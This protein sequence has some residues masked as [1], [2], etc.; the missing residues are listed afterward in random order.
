[1][2]S[3][4]PER[5]E[6]RAS[7]RSPT[8]RR[9]VTGADVLLAFSGFL[10]A[11]ALGVSLMSVVIL[12]G[13]DPD[14]AAAGMIPTTVVLW[15]VALWWSLSRRGW[16]RADLGLVPPAG[17]RHLLWQLPLAW[18]AVTGTTSAVL[19]LALDAPEPVDQGLSRLGFGPVVVAALWVSVVVLGPF[20]EEVLFRRVLLG[21]LEARTGVVLAV[22][23]QAALFGVLHVIPQV[24]LLTFL[25][26]SAAALLARRHRS[27]WPALLLHMLNNAVA[28]TV[29][30]G[31]VA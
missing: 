14:R 12:L 15:C 22:V 26:G 16:T 7:R 20:V 24:I 23:L 30:L 29:L 11:T 4:S 19:L 31:A 17:S 6:G 3:P 28:A 21:W 9:P 25:L 18:L 8:Y 2:S 10:M 27:L 13:L 5:P 1:M